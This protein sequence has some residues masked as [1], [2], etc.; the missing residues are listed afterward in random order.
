MAVSDPT[1]SS[2]LLLT[3]TYAPAAGERLHLSP[4]KPLRKVLDAGGQSRLRTRHDG[5]PL[6]EFRY[7]DSF[8]VERSDEAIAALKN[9]C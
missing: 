3:S 8:S 1:D 2:A 6:P 7:G 9:E 4:V 5:E